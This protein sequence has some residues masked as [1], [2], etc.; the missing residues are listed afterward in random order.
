[1]KTNKKRIFIVDDHPMIREGIANVINSEADMVLCG[2]APTATEA[3]TSIP[4]AKPDA[5]IVDLSL[6]GFSG[7]EL[8]RHLRLRNPKLPL[9]AYTMHEEAIYAHR[10]V[11]A[12]ATAYVTKRE[13]TGKL[14]LALRQALHKI[15]PPI[16]ATLPLGRLSRRELEVFKLRGEGFTTHHIAAQLQVSRKTVDAHLLRIRDKLGLASSR[17][18]L[19]NAVNWVQHQPRMQ[20]ARHS[21]ANQ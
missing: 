13:S 3:L 14:L 20:S 11:G 9:V 4:K 15:S 5:V 10:A 17:A 16:P 2:A 6:E 1:M 7:L 18:V 12:G 19:E 8:I 21:E